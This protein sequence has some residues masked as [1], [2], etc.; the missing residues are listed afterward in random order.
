[1]ESPFP[2]AL[3]KQRINPTAQLDVL[4]LNPTAPLDPA[5]PVVATTFRVTE[6]YLSGPMSR[7][8][9]WLNELQPAMF[10]EMSPEL[11]A[12]RGV[13]H[14]DWVVISSP[15]GAIEARAMVTPRLRPLRVQGQTMHQV[16]LPIHFGFAGEIAGSAA[17]ELLPIVSDP[18]VSMHEGKAFTCQVHKGRLAH[19]SDVPSAPVKPRPQP[20]PMP[21]TPHQ[22]QPE[23]RTA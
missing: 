11:A 22:A 9:S 23:G 15:R 1:V 6:H 16:C 10:V 7:W 12:E 19:P 4:P 8:D 13:T 2:N 20:D 17:N 14:G 3:Y 5:F 21:G 18:N